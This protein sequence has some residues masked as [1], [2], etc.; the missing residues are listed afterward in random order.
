MEGVTIRQDASH[1]WDRPKPRKR[2]TLSEGVIMKVQI[3]ANHQT[4]YIIRVRQDH[5]SLP[6]RLTYIHTG[7]GTGCG[8]YI[9]VNLN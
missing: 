1:Y 6:M 4:K 3:Q 5:T 2:S 7:S 8:G 9:Y